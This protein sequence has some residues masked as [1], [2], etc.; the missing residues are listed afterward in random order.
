VIKLE[1][2]D[3]L[4]TLKIQIALNEKMHQNGNITDRMFDAANKLLLENLT[5]I[6][7]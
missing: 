4:V 3:K 5:N 1:N 6:E 2:L 7:T